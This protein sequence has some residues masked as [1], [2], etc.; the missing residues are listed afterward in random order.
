MILIIAAIGEGTFL[1]GSVL[2]A[3]SALMT[4]SIVLTCAAAAGFLLVPFQSADLLYRELNTKQSYMLF[5]TPRSPKSIL[6]AKILTVII[7]LAVQGVVFGI[8][9][10]VDAGILYRASGSTEG[11]LSALLSSVG[12][13]GFSVSDLVLFAAKII[14]MT[15]GFI[16]SVLMAYFFA[17][18]VQSTVLN[19]RK[20]G[21]WF[22]LLIF[23]I[24]FIAFISITGRVTAAVPEAYQFAV[25]ACMDAACVV[26]FFFLASSLMEKK[27]SV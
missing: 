2:W 26:L 13:A 1:L 23:V 24:L 19:G 22:S 17:E 11:L 14:G 8:F 21:V 5:L 7:W 4:G 16:L 27:L 3:D 10:C 18:I 12:G 9:S 15:Y 6:G 25:A 20:G